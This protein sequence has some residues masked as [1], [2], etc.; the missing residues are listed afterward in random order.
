[1]CD[2]TAA[3]LARIHELGID[4]NMIDPIFQAM[5]ASVTAGPWTVHGDVAFPTGYDDRRPLEAGEVI[6]ND[7]GC[8]YQGYASDFGRT[9]VV[10]GRPEP[11]LV[12]LYH[13]WRDVV[14]AVV[15][16]I[17]PG[18]TN[19]DLTRAAVE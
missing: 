8:T 6:W 5:P 15:P 2:L 16:A 11:E 9:W 4:A 7:S 13:R 14:D 19:A 12:S 1:R 17:R 18:A 10:G 3:F